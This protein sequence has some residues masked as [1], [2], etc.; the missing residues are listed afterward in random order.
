MKYVKV[1]KNIDEIHILFLV[2]KKTI[3]KKKAQAYAWA[4]LSRLNKE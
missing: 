2:H 1:M 3:S 4:K